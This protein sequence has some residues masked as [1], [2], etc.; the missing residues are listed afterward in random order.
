MSRLTSVIDLQL[1]IGVILDIKFATL[2][3]LDISE[4]CVVVTFLI[5]THI[6][7][8]VFNKL[9]IFTEKQAQMFQAESILTLE[10]NGHTFSF[11]EKAADYID[12]KDEQKGEM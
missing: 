5:P 2:Q 8:I 3:L 6:A 12:Q 1:A 11:V 4:G 10:C 7:E 9:T